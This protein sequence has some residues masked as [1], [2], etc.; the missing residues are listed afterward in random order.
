M[1]RSTA[2]RI[3]SFDRW[4]R[5][6]AGSSAID[7]A[8]APSLGND[9]MR[10]LPLVA[11][12]VRRVREV[13]VVDGSVVDLGRQCP[14]EAVKGRQDDRSLRRA[15]VAEDGTEAFALR[16]LRLGECAH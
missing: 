4:L 11:G 7:G 1:P 8:W 2:P 15:Q 3:S 13:V 16:R 9:S 6:R 12:L 5:P 10:C 14:T